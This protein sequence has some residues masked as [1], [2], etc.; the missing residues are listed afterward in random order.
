M[1]NTGIY[2]KDGRIIAQ[3]GDVKIYETDYDIF[4]EIGPAH[5]LWTLASELQD[6]IEQ[7]N[8]KPRGHCLEIGLGLGVASRYILSCS[9]VKTLT[10]LEINEDVIKTYK[11][12]KKYLDNKLKL[13]NINKNH[14]I[15][16]DEG[17]KYI[18]TTNKKFD[19]IFL[20]YY[21]LIDEETL[22]DIEVT[23]YWCK[24]ILRSGGKI[25]GWFDKYTPD[26]YIKEFNKI[27]QNI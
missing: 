8:N 24:K 9:K 19:F 25:I 3:S 23:T 20:D 17:L 27:F 7:I 10:T 6:Y 18:K 13:K 21:T 2:F 22:A 14:I 26:N 1:K 5:T 4:L 11:K 12:T 16:N 15:I